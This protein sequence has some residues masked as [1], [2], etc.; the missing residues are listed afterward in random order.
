MI[1]PYACPWDQL[2]FSPVKVSLSLWIKYLR[3][4]DVVYWLY[5]MQ[6]CDDLTLWNADDCRLFINQQPRHNHHH[7]YSFSVIVTA[8]AA[9]ADGVCWLCMLTVIL[10]RSR[11][12]QS[13]SLASTLWFIKQLL[14]HTHSSAI[15]PLWSLWCPAG[16]CGDTQIPWG[17]MSSVSLTHSPLLLF[18]HTPDRFLGAVASSPSTSLS[19]CQVARG[20]HD[21]EWLSDGQTPA[22]LCPRWIGLEIGQQ[23]RSPDV[24]CKAWHKEGPTMDSISA[25]VEVCSLLRATKA[26][27][28]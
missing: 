20:Q 3:T 27:R 26:K 5:K 1:I 11:S 15:W 25:S 17:G 13:C 16:G 8:A 7:F 4:G 10:S 9:A 12:L 24:C 28:A 19:P 23:K 14:F 21:G 18:Q 22:L 2:F 6:I